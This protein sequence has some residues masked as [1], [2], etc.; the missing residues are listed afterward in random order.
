LEAITMHTP[1]ALA[2]LGRTA[3]LTENF[4]PVEIDG[5]MAANRL[6]R[7]RVTGLNPEGVPLGVLAA[8]E[9]AIAQPSLAAAV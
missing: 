8:A 9:A 1:K 6:V 2:E 4:L 3:A 5:R 7:V